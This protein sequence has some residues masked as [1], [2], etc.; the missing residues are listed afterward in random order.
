MT[1]LLG[2]VGGVVGGYVAANVLKVGTVDGINLESV[3][4]ATLG[5]VAVIFIARAARGSRRGRRGL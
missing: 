3:V 4:I 1:I 2:I 5:A